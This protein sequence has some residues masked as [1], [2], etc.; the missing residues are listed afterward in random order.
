MKTLKNQK[1]FGLIEGLLIVIA[2]ALI[3]F[4]G[5]YV[6]NANKQETK[7]SDSSIYQE[8][9]NNVPAETEEQTDYLTVEELG[10]KADKSSVPGAY[11]KI[12]EDEFTYAE[13]PEV[14]VVGLYD[15]AYDN[16]ENAQGSKCSD[17]DYTS[18]ITIV[19]VISETNRDSKYSEYAGQSAK[20]DFP[21]VLSDQENI[22][23]DGMLY[24]YMNIEGIQSIPR[25]A[26]VG[27][28]K[29][30]KEIEENNSEV[31]AQLEKSRASFEEL[32]KSFEKQ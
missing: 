12:M 11:Y 23:K 22:K 29:T 10:I 6:Y 24:Y 9:E 18:L 21:G 2:L 5:F 20:I 15:E 32:V 1:G 25:C 14:K 7:I 13:F 19:Q 27:G 4:V 31:F 16:T 28:G 26:Y 3:V 8:Q 30:Q 17:V